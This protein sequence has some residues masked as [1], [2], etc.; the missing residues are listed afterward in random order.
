MKE[1]DWLSIHKK[2]TEIVRKV[3]N[4]LKTNYELDSPYW[5]LVLTQKPNFKKDEYISFNV[6]VFIEEG[7]ATILRD[8]TVWISPLLF[9]EYHPS[10]GLPECSDL[11]ASLDY[12]NNIKQPSFFSYTSKKSLSP[13]RYMFKQSD[14]AERIDDLGKCVTDFENMSILKSVRMP[15]D[16]QQTTY[17]IAG[18]KYYAPYSINDIDCILFAQE[19]NEH[20]ENAIQIRRW[21]PIEKGKE[22][23]KS[24]FMH[25]YEYGYISRANNQELHS[26]MTKKDSRILFAKIYDK[27][28]HIIGGLEAFK[29]ELVN[30]YVPPFILDY[31]K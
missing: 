14:K 15:K 7:V 5:E 8:I 29:K 16:M 24:P 12:F 20:D 30:F 10:C 27:K 21:F 22:D 4:Y 25:T 28:V 18:L 23:I 6:A 3:N 26:F 19:N 13:K 17:D 9:I 1:E 11:P 31:L 2:F